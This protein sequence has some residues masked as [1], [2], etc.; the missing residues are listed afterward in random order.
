MIA[1]LPNL[2]QTPSTTKFTLQKSPFL[3]GW[4]LK[5]SRIISP[6]KFLI[7]PW[8][9]GWNTVFFRIAFSVGTGT[10]WWGAILHSYIE[11]Y[12][13]PRGPIERW[14]ITTWYLTSRLRPFVYPS[15]QVY[16]WSL[17]T[18][19]R[20]LNT[21][22]QPFWLISVN[23]VIWLTHAPCSV[24]Q[25]PCFL[26]SHCYKRC[27]TDIAFSDWKSV[28]IHPDAQSYYDSLD[29]DMLMWL[30]DNLHTR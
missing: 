8:W 11:L 20:S 22:W 15:H 25:I 21:Q 3:N 19:M 5:Y 10:W 12:V 26:F 30:E 18:K 27:L 6:M 7:T 1:W 24:Q 29:K 2:Q 9:Y 28:A 14:R 23:P 17:S 13:S 4:T 16:V